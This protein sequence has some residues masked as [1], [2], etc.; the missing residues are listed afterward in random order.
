MSAVIHCA[1]DLHVKCSENYPLSPPTVIKPVNA[2]GLSENQILELQKNLVQM[3]QQKIGEV[4]IMDIG[5]YLIFTS[6][7]HHF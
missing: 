7:D 3:A 1:V 2:K 4:M 5:L 6:Y